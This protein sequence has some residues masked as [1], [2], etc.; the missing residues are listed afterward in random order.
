MPTIGAPSASA[1]YPA[2]EPPLHTTTDAF[3][4]ARSAEPERAKH[5][6]IACVG[7]ARKYC[8]L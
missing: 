1:R 6:N 3:R 8:A 5:A 4:A 7:Q 2:V